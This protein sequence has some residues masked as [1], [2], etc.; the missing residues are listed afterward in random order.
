MFPRSVCLYNLFFW[1]DLC[2]YFSS[3]AVFACGCRVARLLTMRSSYV[4]ARVP[5]QTILKPQL[6][7]IGVKMLMCCC[8]GLSCR[9]HVTQLLRECWQGEGSL[10]AMWW[11]A[12]PCCGMRGI[13]ERSRIQANTRAVNQSFLRSICLQRISVPRVSRLVNKL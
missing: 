3:C 11:T 5:T 7:R 4:D 9:V 13:H 8:E 1:R 2:S 10:V 6:A 12:G